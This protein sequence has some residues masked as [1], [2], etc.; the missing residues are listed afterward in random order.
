MNLEEVKQIAHLSRLAI[1]DDEA[2]ASLEQLNKVFQLVEKM[3]AVDTEGVIPMAHPIEMVMVVAQPLREDAVTEP[4]MR[5]ANL[6]NAPASFEGLFLV[7]KV[8]E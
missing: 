1:T 6:K 3:Q 7:P 8:I 5:E 2:S 4:D